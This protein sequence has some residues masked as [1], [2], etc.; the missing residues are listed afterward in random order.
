MDPNMIIAIRSADIASKKLTF[1]W[2]TENKTNCLFDTRYNILSSSCGKCPTT[3]NHTTVTCTDVPTDGSTCTFR[4]QTVICGN[5]VSE[6]VI[7]V[8]LK[9]YNCD[10]GESDCTGAI[11]SAS[12]FGTLLA[13]VL[14]IIT[15]TS[16]V[17]LSS[18]R[19][20]NVRIT[21]N[22]QDSPVGDN[23]QHQDLSS[24]TIDTRKNPAYCQVNI[25]DN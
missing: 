14:C 21:F 13:I 12:F 16:A 15:C 11:V 6:S 2:T 7:H 22:E 5:M 19:Y 18:V 25:V 4:V 3:T 17:V 20:N 23:L 10:K 1:D 24:S 8:V 9:E